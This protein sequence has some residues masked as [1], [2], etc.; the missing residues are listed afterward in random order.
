MIIQTFCRIKY[1]T[2]LT[3]CVTVLGKGGSSGLELTGS[4]H[5]IAGKKEVYYNA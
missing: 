3:F 4:P 5:G 1:K 2:L